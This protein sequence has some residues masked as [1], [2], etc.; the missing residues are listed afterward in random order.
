MQT[1]VIPNVKKD[2]LSH[3]IEWAK[4]LGGKVVSVANEDDGE[5]TVVILVP[6][7]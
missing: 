3:Y 6:S 5:F 1:I 7:E 4:S 2:R